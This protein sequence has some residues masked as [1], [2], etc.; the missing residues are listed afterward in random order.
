LSLSLALGQAILAGFKWAASLVKGII[1]KRKTQQ[2]L[3]KKQEILRKLTPDEK[4][5]L[6][7]YILNAE[8]SRNFLIEDG[9]AGGLVAKGI[10]YRP[11]TIGSLLGGWAHNMQPWAREFLDSHRECLVGASAG[12]EN[13]RGW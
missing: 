7:P 2:V 13:S 11:S 3:V 1:D 9:V 5:Y 8:N 6:A 10:L 12:R 4:A